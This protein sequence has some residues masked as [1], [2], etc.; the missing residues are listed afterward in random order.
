MMTKMRCLKGLS[1]HDP[2]GVTEMREGAEK[3][4]IVVLVDEDEDEQV[5]LA[6]R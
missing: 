5:F 3:K 4:S 2:K 6:C 1:Y